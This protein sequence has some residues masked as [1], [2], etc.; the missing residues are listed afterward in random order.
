MIRGA[1]PRGGMVVEHSSPWPVASSSGSGSPAPP[2]TGQRTESASASPPPMRTR[3]QRWP[4]GQVNR[5][6]MSPPRGRNSSEKRLS[7]TAAAGQGGA[8]HNGHP[9][10]GAGDGPSG[11]EALR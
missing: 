3:S 8:Q 5:L 6:D 7:H 9:L 2:Q 10:G 4:W 1:S 11:S